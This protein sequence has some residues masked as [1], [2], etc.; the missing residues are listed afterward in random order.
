MN[1]FLWISLSIFLGC[2]ASSAMVIIKYYYVNFKNTF[3]LVYFI[4][5]IFLLY[6]SIT[7]LWYAYYWFLSNNISMAKFFPIVKLVELSIPI[8]IDICFYKAHLKLINYIG[9]GLAGV[10]IACI[11]Y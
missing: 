6:T 8:I 5:I 3:N 1:N 4:P 9:L 7:I 2:L 11:A 10:A